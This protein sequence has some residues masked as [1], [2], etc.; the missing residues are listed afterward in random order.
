MS[1]YLKSLA[2]HRKILALNI[3]QLKQDIIDNKNDAEYVRCQGENLK[4]TL[5]ETEKML[6]LCDQQI[7][8]E[9]L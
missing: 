2:I 1:A 8:E 7:E 3:E 4:A 6:E 5:A 9:K